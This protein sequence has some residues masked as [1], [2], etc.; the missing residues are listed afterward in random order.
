LLHEGLQVLLGQ[1]GKAT[2]LRVVGIGLPKIAAFH[3]AIEKHL[4]APD[5]QPLVAKA[6]DR[7]Q[8]L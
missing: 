4:E 1:K 7:G 8:A 2:K 6:A 3:T 5:V